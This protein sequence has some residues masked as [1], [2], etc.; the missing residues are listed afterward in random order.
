M[1]LN[2]ALADVITNLESFGLSPLDLH[3]TVSKGG[4][5]G[6]ILAGFQTSF[7]HSLIPSVGEAILEERH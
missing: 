7:Q 3:S 1:D 4:I 5:Q 2:E 6:S